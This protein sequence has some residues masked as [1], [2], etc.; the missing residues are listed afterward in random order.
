MP[1]DP[2]SFKDPD[3]QSFNA[4]KFDPAT[5]KDPD[6]EDQKQQAQQVAELAKISPT[7]AALQGMISAISDQAAGLGQVA[8]GAALGPL[9]L[10]PIQKA[11]AQSD[12]DY[13][14]AKQAHPIAAMAGYGVGTVAPTL[15]IPAAGGE[16]LA[17]K[18]GQ[19]ALMGADLA[20]TQYVEGN[21]PNT[22]AAMAAGGAALGA[23]VPAIGSAIS[24]AKKW[25]TG[26]AGNVGKE[27]TGALDKADQSILNQSLG[28]SQRTGIHLTP[29]EAS[30][31]TSQLADEARLAVG[32][33]TRDLVENTLAKRKSDI[34]G[35]AKGITKDM[36]PEGKEKAASAVNK[37]YDES[38][39]KIV[40]IGKLK[41]LSD[42]PAFKSAENKMLNTLGKDAPE[43]GTVGYLD[44][45][46]KYIDDDISVAVNSGKSRSG[47]ELQALQGVKQKLVDAADSVSPEYVKAREGAQRLI[48]Q[49]KLETKLNEALN[50]AGEGYPSQ[51]RKAWFSSK[52][53]T[54][55]FFKDLTTVTDDPKTIQRAKDLQTI[56]NRVR[57]SKYSKLAT[58]IPS[59]G[60]NTESLSV[61]QNIF[62][63]IKHLKDPLGMHDK[64]M[65][66]LISN[67]RWQSEL[68]R[69]SNSTLNPDGTAEK[70]GNILMRAYIRNKTSDS[71]KEQ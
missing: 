59:G 65:I 28:A 15:A 57:T 46:K 23:A 67:P 69:L 70:F 44:T 12:A 43:A 6:V 17:S 33:K 31:R 8:Y 37:L 9:A 30:Q 22:R 25:V 47:P 41:E 5:F 60:L 2:S 39:S 11:K 19:G 51:I 62:T 21:D 13:A 56:L 49:K 50:D 32:D 20:G 66:E 64:A 58:K 10:D 53:N 16:T 34:V 18:I 3:A 55:E 14:Q 4:Q 63:R 45:I 42:Y 68:N 52:A 29:G 26:N 24:G 1:F 27:V 35:L 7:R 71:D 54:D 61:V 38:Y 36:I 40:P 48:I